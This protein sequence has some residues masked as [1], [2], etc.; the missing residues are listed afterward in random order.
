MKPATPLRLKL[1]APAFD[2]P[3]GLD[4]A[5]V[6]DAN[7][8]D[9]VGL[10][11]YNLAVYIVAAANAYPRLVG[12]LHHMVHLAVLVPGDM[13]PHHRDAVALLRDLGEAE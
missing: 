10:V 8:A 5:M 9:L 3:E 1:A 2:D 6:K 4:L 7:G 13:T 11:D 12:A